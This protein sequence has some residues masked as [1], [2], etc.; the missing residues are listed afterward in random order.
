MKTRHL[1]FVLLC[2]KVVI[3]PVKADI[4]LPAVFNDN[5][6]LQQQ[7]EVKGLLTPNTGMAVLMDAESPDC[8]HPAKKKHAG[9]RMALWALAKTYGFDKMH[10]R[11]PEVQS[12]EKEGRLMSIT[13][14]LFGSVNGLTSHGKAIRN[15]LIAGSNKRFYPAN[16]ALTGNKVFVFSPHVADPVA[17]RYCFDNT[18]AG[19]IFTVEGNLP[20]SSFRTDN[21]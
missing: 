18:S 2:L 3:L 4:K 15:F 7:S 1:F 9:E 11:S 21:W 19:E 8:I 20:V 17:V 6:V 12:I 16:A 14:D 10:Y 13:F 5:M